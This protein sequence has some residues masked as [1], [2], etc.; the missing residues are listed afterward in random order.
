MRRPAKYH[1]FFMI[2]GIG[3]FGILSHVGLGQAYQNESLQEEG[4]RY[5]TEQLEPTDG[6][7]ETEGVAEEEYPEEYPEGYPIELE[8]KRAEHERFL[9]NLRQSSFRDDQRSL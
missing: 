4:P 5:Y 8:P 9:Q 2:S 7:I 1:Q 3:I 6:F